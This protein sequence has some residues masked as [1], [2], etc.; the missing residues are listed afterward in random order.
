MKVNEAMFNISILTNYGFEKIDKDQEFAD[1]NYVIAN[2]EYL[3]N[4]GHSRRG[5]MYYILVQIIM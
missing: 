4:I 2:Y 3:L 5:Q 1:D